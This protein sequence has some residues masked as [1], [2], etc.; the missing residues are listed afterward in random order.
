MTKGLMTLA[1]LAALTLLPQVASAGGHS[2]F[3]LA[4]GVGSGPW[5]GSV[6]YSTGGGHGHYGCGPSYS[7]SAAYYAPRAYYAPPPVVY[8]QPPIV[9]AQPQVI[10][11]PPP[12][13]IY[14]APQPAPA[15]YYAPP[16]VYAAPTPSPYYS[17]SASYYGR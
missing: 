1:T 10:Y 9:Y 6:G 16:V 11:A 2:S 14:A 5:F 12:Q 3:S 8:A 17:A 4:I 13:V 15:T 7:F